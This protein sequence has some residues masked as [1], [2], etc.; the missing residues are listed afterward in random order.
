[1]KRSNFLAYLLLGLSIVGCVQEKITPAFEAAKDPKR[2]FYV[3][4]PISEIT[5]I[6]QFGQDIGDIPVVG[7]IFQEL[8]RMFANISIDNDN[9]SQVYVEPSLFRFQELNRVD[10]SIVTKLNLEKVLLKASLRDPDLNFVLEEGEK[11]KEP[12]LKFIKRLEVYV[13]HDVEHFEEM[14]K[15][16]KSK[17]MPLP[18]KNSTLLLSYDK[19]QSPNSLG[20]DSKCIDLKISDVDWKALLDKERDFIVQTVLIVD[21]VP[22]S[23]MKLGGTVNFSLGIDLGF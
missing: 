2:S 15:K 14:K 3:S 13:S 12:S 19:K 10:F 9:G 7:G 18:L 4:V 22:E 1:M 20:C 21:A 16:F 5:V 8:A 11:T 6:D 17:E 23:N